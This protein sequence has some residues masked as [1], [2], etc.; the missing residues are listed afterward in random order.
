MVSWAQKSYKSCDYFI[1]ISTSSNIEIGTPDCKLL[2]SE[3]AARI[4]TIYT[5]TVAV[6]YIIIILIILLSYMHRYQRV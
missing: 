3:D 5:C 6:L 2:L 4:M 1:V